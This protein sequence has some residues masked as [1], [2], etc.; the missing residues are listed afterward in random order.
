MFVDMKDGFQLLKSL[1]FNRAVNALKVIAGYYMSNAF[2]KPIVMGQPLSIALEPT[3]ACNLSCPQ[4]P[5]GLKKFSRPTG[6]L[7]QNLYEHI[8]D[9]VSRNTG[10]LTLYFQGEPYINPL[11]FEM[12]KYAK[13]K[14]M[15]TST[16]TNAHFLTDDLAKRT[17]ESGLSRIIVSIDGTDQETY[18]K[19]RV[20]GE[21]KK[22][23]EGTARLAKWKRQLN[24]ATPAIILQFIVFKSNE[25]QIE[26]IKK[27]GKELGVDKVAIK[28]AQ[29]YDFESD[30]VWIPD[31]GKYSRYEA[32]NGTMNIKN[33]LANRCSRIWKSTVITWD[34][35]VIPCCFDKDASHELGKIEEDIDF[36][37]IWNGS[38]Y[39]DFRQSVLSSRKSIEICQ[40]CTEGTKV[41]N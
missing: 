33:K 5:S 15:Y 1:N 27:L 14:R 31:N 20:G 36:K 38:K 28:T 13:R 39:K 34:G 41:W 29:I 4:C 3:T 12:V 11:F 16:S 23:K 40:N 7:K 30:D 26:E 22:A 17:V 10:F 24:S 35:R 32:L 2:R 9:Q 19:Y 8:L 25:H 21:L 18:A 37:D 6:N